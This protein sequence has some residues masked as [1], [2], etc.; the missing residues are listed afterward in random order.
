[1]A[2]VKSVLII[3]VLLFATHCP[4]TDYD[5]QIAEVQREI[6]ALSGAHE[7]NKQELANLNKQLA[8]LKKRISAISGELKAVETEIGQRE[9]DLVY[10]EA[11]LHEKARKHYLFLRVY[12]PLLPFLSA[13]GAGDAF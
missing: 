8:D 1:M 12:D 9:E 10:A 7:T 2:K 11:V 3:L 4:P 13:K 5:C 6:D